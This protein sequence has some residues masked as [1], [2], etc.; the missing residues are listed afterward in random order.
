MLKK[1]YTLIL[2][3]VSCLTATLFIVR[4]TGY[5]PW[6]DYDEDGNIDARDLHTFSKEYGTTGDPTKNVNVTNERLDVNVI[7][8]PNIKVI[9][10]KGATFVNSWGQGDKL[11]L[12]IA[13]AYGSSA[14]DPSLVQMK[15]TVHTRFC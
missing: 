11:F 2:A 10:F 7:N 13:N 6:F 14:D 4:S 12:G 3:L 1:R 8:F 5:D 15:L 9:S